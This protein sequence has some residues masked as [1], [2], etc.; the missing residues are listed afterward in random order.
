MNDIVASRTMNIT[1]PI[2]DSVFILA[3]IALVAV[4]KNYRAL[5]FGLIGGVLYFF[6]D[7]VLFHLVAGSRSI[8]EGYSL[9]WVLLWMSMSYGFT[10]FLLIWLA[11][12]KDEHLFGYA[13]IVFIWWIACPQIADLFSKA[14]MFTIQ[15]TTANYHGIMG[16]ILFVSYAV[17]IVRNMFVVPARRVNVL[18]LLIIGVAVQFGWEFSLLVSGIRSDGFALGEALKTLAVNSLTETNL[19]MPSMFAIFVYVNRFLDKKKAARLGIDPLLLTQGTT[20][21]YKR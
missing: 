3:L 13:A 11:L 15:R 5:I 21:E 20:Y 1:Y 14:P 18:W 9:F 17:L 7:Y 19:G 16:I 6:V 2:L 12:S 10:N 4:R 8:S